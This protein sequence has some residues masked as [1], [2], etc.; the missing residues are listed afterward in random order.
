MARS[1]VLYC[2]HS[3]IVSIYLA[4]P[5]RAYQTINAR[6]RS[7]ER[8]GMNKEAAGD[9]YKQQQIFDCRPTLSPQVMQWRDI[10][11]ENALKRPG[12]EDKQSRR[13]KGAI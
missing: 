4:S 2:T 1:S 12:V 13:N 3:A 6:S 10:A 7:H 11:S 8:V 5:I 9:Q